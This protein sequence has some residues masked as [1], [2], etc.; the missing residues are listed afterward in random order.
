MRMFIATSPISRL[1]ICRPFTASGTADPIGGSAAEYAKF[2]Q[3][4][5]VKWKAV[6]ESSGAAAE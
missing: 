2:T 6:V 5:Y 3:S 1:A 4:E